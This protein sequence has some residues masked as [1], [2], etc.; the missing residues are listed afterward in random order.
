MNDV[1]PPPQA[2]QEEVL[3]TALVRTGTVSEADLSRVR[4]MRQG[5]AETAPLSSLLVRLGLRN[6]FV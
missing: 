3:A 5:Q 2:E 4:Q 1:A 6:N